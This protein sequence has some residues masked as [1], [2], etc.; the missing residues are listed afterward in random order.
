MIDRISRL[1]RRNKTAGDH[2]A[3]QSRKTTAASPSPVTPG[4][5]EAIAGAERE[6]AAGVSAGAALTLARGELPAELRCR[7]LGQVEDSAALLDIALHDK[8]ARVRLAA[9]ERLSASEDLEQLRRHSNDKAVQRHARDVLKTL[10][11]D[12]QT[13]QET[14]ARIARLLDA[15]AQHAARGYEPLYDAKLESLNNSWREIAAQADAAAQERFAELAALA[16]DTVTRHAA[17][18]AA[19]ENAIAAKKELIAACS[20]LETVVTRLGGEDLSASLAAVAALR[21]TQQ[22]RWDEAVALTAADAPLATRFRQATRTLD[23]WLAAAAELPH[24]NRDVAPVLAAVAGEHGDDTQPEPTLDVLDDWQAQLDAVRARIDWPHGL[25][26]APLLAEL[27]TAQHRIAQKRRAVQA[28]VREQVAQLRKRRHALRHMIDEGQLRVAVRTHHWLQKRIAELPAREAAQ[29]TSALAPLAEALAKLHDW[30]EFASIPKKTELCVAMEALATPAT[31]IPARAADVRAL[32]ARWNA[33]CAADPEADPELRARFDRAAG[34]AFAPCAAWYDA[35]HRLQDENLAQ[36]AALCDELAALAASAPADA[37]GWRALEQ[38]ERELRARW[39]TLQPVRWPEARVTQDRFHQLLDGLHR[40]LVGER[41]RGAESRRAVI[42][43]AR[44]LLV[45]EPLESALAAARSL[46]D[47]WKRCGWTD[48]RDDRALWQEFRT[49]V[50]AVFARR[51]QARA[52]ERAA[53]EAQAAEAARRRA[54]EE[55]RREQRRLEAEAARQ[56][57]IDA[58]LAVG[59]VEAAALQGAATDLSGLQA[60]LDALPGKSALVSALRSRC[61]QLQQDM[62][63]AASVLDANADKLAALTLELEIL[64]DAPSPPELAQARMQAKLAKLND[65]LRHRTTSR[66]EDPRHDLENAW[67]AVGPLRA[68]DRAS[69][70]LRFQALPRRR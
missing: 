34:Q 43:R 47:E 3:G 30:Y 59:D 10:R 54:G 45:Q 37:A 51:D 48:P 55:A 25:A 15:I 7:A 1:F 32:R 63:P 26:P 70:L 50:D 69:L 2:P 22:T 40:M 49:T 64:C 41:Q 56:A 60:R 66:S 8:V 27:E 68:D 23:R 24:A 39:K 42:A 67:L 46:Q 36:R 19:R 11:G 35:Q 65:A 9:A 33:L 52:A 18:I 21:S 16:R 4:N 57:E 31:D 17:E 38:H 14:N 29:E 58:A 12:E 53:R 20:E 44:E 6:L 5:A 13:R 28:D 61:A 62:A